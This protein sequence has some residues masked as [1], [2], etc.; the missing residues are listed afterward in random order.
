M[1]IAWRK[2][3]GE[4]LMF[5]PVQKIKLNKD[6]GRILNLRPLKQKMS[7]ALSVVSS[8]SALQ[9]LTCW[10]SRGILHSAPAGLYWIV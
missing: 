2:Q 10:Q 5:F 1:C 3:Q 4:A 9:S 7:W 6:D 8:A